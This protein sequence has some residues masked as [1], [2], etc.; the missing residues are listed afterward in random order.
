MDLTQLSLSELKKLHKA[1]TAA[2]ANYADR[3]KSQARA[4][5]KAKARELGFDLDELLGNKQSRKTPP[6][7]AKYRNPVDN[8]VTWSGRGRGPLWFVAELASGK[9]EENLAI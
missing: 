6:K 7:T 8:A 1:L 4:K 3:E 5:L 9:S 2:I